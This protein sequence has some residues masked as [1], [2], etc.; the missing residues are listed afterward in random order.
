MDVDYTLVLETLEHIKHV[1]LTIPLD[2]LIVDP[3]NLPPNSHHRGHVVVPAHR[4][5]KDQIQETDR[6]PW[7]CSC[8]IP[9]KLRMLSAD[10]KYYMLCLCLFLSPYLCL[11]LGL[12]F[13]LRFNLF[14]QI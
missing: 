5:Q 8:L 13:G 1:I 11:C 3:Y 6:N 14:L 2:R 4:V 9:Y 12:G 10:F 7:I